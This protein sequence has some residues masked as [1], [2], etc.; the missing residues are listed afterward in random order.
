MQLL[1][2]FSD[3]NAVFVTIVQ[4]DYNISSGETWTWNYII[5]DY[6]NNIVWTEQKA[7][8]SLYIPDEGNTMWNTE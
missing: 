7:N 8:T 2:T 5:F 4:E 1:L 6:G 3:N